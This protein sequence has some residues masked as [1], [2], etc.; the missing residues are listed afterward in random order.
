MRTNIHI[1]TQKLP[2]SAS[3]ETDLWI[4]WEGLGLEELRIIAQFHIVASVQREFKRSE[5]GI[6][7]LHSVRAMDFIHPTK[8]ADFSEQVKKQKAQS[9]RQ[10]SEF[11]K[12]IDS[13]PTAE[14]AK[15]MAELSKQ[16]KK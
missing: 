15:I 2:T 10:V 12:M 9:E 16:E 6:P 1:L 7:T 13:L 5:A 11:Q 8:Y 14:R 4:D 3:T